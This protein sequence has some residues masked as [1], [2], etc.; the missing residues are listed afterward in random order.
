[1][2]HYVLQIKN[3]ASLPGTPWAHRYVQS[4]DVDFVP[5]E[6]NPPYPNGACVWTETIEEAHRFS[7][8]AEAYI[9]YH[10]ASTTIPFRSDGLPNRPLTAFSMLIVKVGTP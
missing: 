2:S 5:P 10:S 6:P 3:Y 1:M 7:S 4:F 8:P 9:A